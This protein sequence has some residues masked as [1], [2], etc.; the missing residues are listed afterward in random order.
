MAF[1]VDIEGVGKAAVHICLGS[2][3]KL[4]PFPDFVCIPPDT[5]LTESVA[6]IG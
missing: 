4:D 2:G 5:A 6:S 1:S 3:S